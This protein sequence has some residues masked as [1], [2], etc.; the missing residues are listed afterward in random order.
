MSDLP[1]LRE[2]LDP[3]LKRAR[4]HNVRV[5]GAT[6]SRR[7]GRIDGGQTKPT[8]PSVVKVMFTDQLDQLKK[9]LPVQL[10]RARR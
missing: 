4:R 8:C 7:G 3:T 1:D 5:H 9:M 2:I 6:S 10:E